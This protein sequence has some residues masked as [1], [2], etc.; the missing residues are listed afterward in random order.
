MSLS[1]LL[2]APVAPMADSEA[3]ALALDMFGLAGSAQALTSERDQNFLMSTP[4]G[5]RFVLKIAN[6]AEDAAVTQFQAAALAHVAEVDPSLPTPRV[7]PTRAGE[8]SGLLTRP[9]EAP[10]VVRMLTFL[11]GL[12]LHDVESTQALKRNIGAAHARLGLALA[13]F[14][15]PASDH[16]L[17]WDMKRAGRLAELRESIPEHS[18][19]ALVDEAMDRFKT[20]VEP[21]LGDLRSQV[22][23]NDLN[24]HNLVV[25][26][27][28][29]ER[30]AGILDFGDMVLTPL[31][32]DV[33]IAAAYL[34][35]DSGDPLDG[36]AP[37]VAGYH[38][39]SPLRR[40]EAELLADM[41]ATRLLMTVLIT[42]WRAEIHPHNRSYIL[43]NNAPAWSRL[44][45]LM[46]WDRSSGDDPLRAACGGGTTS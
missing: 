44:E 6:P 29:L 37:Y 25:D 30:V 5:S 20:R 42:G 10:R 40:E 41:V 17:P 13:G 11:P 14:S 9:G 15:H 27:D 31:V 8:I 35:S 1:P 19:R 24:Q 23:H 38:A 34:L 7:V 45:K 43:R 28:N 18:R 39:V 21:R 22:V 36:A 12:M 33:A 3:E 26:R 46:A 16:D 32:C 4:D 2:G